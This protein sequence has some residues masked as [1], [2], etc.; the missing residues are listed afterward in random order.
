MRYARWG[1]F[2]GFMRLVLRRWVDFMDVV[3]RGHAYRIA[4]GGEL[5]TP[6]FRLPAF[7]TVKWPLPLK[8]P[9]N[10]D[11]GILRGY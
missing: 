7:G 3:W 11:I 8:P 4:L 1:V 2:L 6:T 5:P 10:R 9:R